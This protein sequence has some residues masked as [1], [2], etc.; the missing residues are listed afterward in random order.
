V[1]YRFF[2]EPDLPPLAV[3]DEMVEALRE[4]LPELPQVRQRYHP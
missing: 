1:D 3:S 2:P 4:A